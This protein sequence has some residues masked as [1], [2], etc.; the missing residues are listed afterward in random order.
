ME[1]TPP[2]LCTNG[3]VEAGEE[4]DDGNVE[5][6]DGC[7]GCAVQPGWVCAR[8]GAGC[9]AAW[10]AADCRSECEWVPVCRDRERNVEGEECDDGNSVAGDGCSLDCKVEISWACEIYQ[11]RES[12]APR[13][14][15]Q[16]SAAAG[17]ALAARDASCADVPCPAHA[18][19]VLF[20]GEPRC[21]CGPGYVRPDPSR[22]PPPPGTNWARR[23]PP[24]VLTGHAACLPPY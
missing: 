10:V 18:E 13:V 5:R 15:D 16:H 4:C 8:V 11:D 19:C 20:G 14:V 9:A 2:P 12:C 24:P 7:E 21:R 23:V 6:G 22:V 3:V 1:T 17:A